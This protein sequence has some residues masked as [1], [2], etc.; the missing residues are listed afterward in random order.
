MF[1][2]IKGAP[3]LVDLLRLAFW[4]RGPVFWKYQVPPIFVASEYFSTVWFTAQSATKRVLWD[5]E[6]LTDACAYTIQPIST[7]AYCNSYVY[8]VFKPLAHMIVLQFYICPDVFC[9]YIFYN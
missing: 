7:R 9:N 1:R 8:V 6:L 3:S 5:G 2:Y 4:S